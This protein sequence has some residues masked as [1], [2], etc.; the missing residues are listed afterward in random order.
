MKL[1]IQLA[2]LAAIVGAIRVES[3]RIRNDEGI[4]HALQRIGVLP[5][6]G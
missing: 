3:P 5:G 2:Q 4:R 6:I 1:A